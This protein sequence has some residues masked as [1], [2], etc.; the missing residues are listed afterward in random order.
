[1]L[2]ILS[3][4]GALALLRHEDRARSDFAFNVMLFSTVVS[5]AVFYPWATGNLNRLARYN[6]APYFVVESRVQPPAIVFGTYARNFFDMQRRQ[7]G[8]WTHFRKNNSVDLDDDVLWFN[9]LGRQ[10]VVAMRQFP[11]RRYYRLVSEST[12]TWKTRMNVVEIT[13]ESLAREARS[14]KGQAG[15]KER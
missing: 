11:N 9:D 15:A 10:N 5:L 8:T 14:A 13:E 4:A 7:S 6:A 12:A 2:A 3:A 1:M